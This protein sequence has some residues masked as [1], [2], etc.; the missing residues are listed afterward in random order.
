MIALLM[1]SLLIALAAAGCGG[2]SSEPSGPT[3]SVI[4]GFAQQGFVSQSTVQAYSVNPADG[5]NETSLVGTT[6]DSTGFFELRLKPQ[7]DPVRLVVSGGSFLSEANGATISSPGTMS[8]LLPSAPARPVT[9]NVNPLTDFID[10]MTVVNVTK[11]NQS[12]LTA[13]SQATSKV[14]Q[15][16]GLSSDPSQL[17]ADYTTTGTDAANLGLVLG[18]LINEDEALCSATPGGLVTALATDLSDGAFDGKDA[19]G[20]PIGYCGGSLAAFAG[21]STFQD[22]L[23]G[24]QQL[25]TISRGFAFGG[26]GNL[27]TTNGLADIATGGSTSYPVAPLALINN[28]IG[29]NA[30]PATISTFAASTPSMNNTRDNATATLLPSGKVLIAGGF[31]NITLETSSLSSTEIYDP[32]S[33]TFAA[34]TPHM[35]DA[36]DSATATLLTNG[37]VLIAGGLVSPTFFHIAPSFLSSTEIYDP[38]SNTFAPSTPSMNAGHASATATLLPNGEVLIAGGFGNA[39]FLSST[40]IYDP[41]S[42]TFASSTPSMNHARDSAT[43]TLLPNDKVLIAGGEFAPSPGVLVTILSSTEIYSP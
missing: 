11:L 27:L 39:G 31:S 30:A 36:R 20:N 38:A 29:A 12:L 13:L 19:N 3:G 35:N 10:Q 41:A 16:Y 22:A 32:A 26:T 33:N 40:E 9:A 28:A 2:G 21:I 24:L 18:A 6:T 7:T 14:E 25:Q 34:S 42:N 15:V 4:S 5:S 1:I 8:V 43:A 23:S 17:V 37:K